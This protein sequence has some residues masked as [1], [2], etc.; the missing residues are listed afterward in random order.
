[1]CFR[2]CSSNLPPVRCR[3]RCGGWWRRGCGQRGL[4]R[5]GLARIHSRT[6]MCLVRFP[7]RLT[8][9]LLDLQVHTRL[10][11]AGYA[12]CSSAA[13]SGFEWG[14]NES[15]RRLDGSAG[16]FEKTAAPTAG[17]AR[18]PI[19]AQCLREQPHSRSLHD[20]ARVAD[21]HALL[22]VGVARRLKLFLLRI[23]P[24]VQNA[25]SGALNSKLSPHFAAAACAPCSAPDPLPNAPPAPQ[26]SNTRAMASAS[27][28]KPEATHKRAYWR[29]WRRRRMQTC[30]APS[31]TRC[32]DS[33]PYACF[34][35][36]I[37]CFAHISFHQCRHD[38]V[39]AVAF[40][41]FR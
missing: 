6:E 31:N 5:R 38:F 30:C 21:V 16:I 27:P 26:R 10:T 12:Q 7:L 14:G 20:A 33:L 23:L 36:I 15:A 25:C 2:A 24:A 1:M 3:C 22:P 37:S 9:A 41:S 32:L 4:P 29:H 11:R 13:V 40:S 39:C 18:R 35:H 8:R 19:N 34:S 17:D 28:S